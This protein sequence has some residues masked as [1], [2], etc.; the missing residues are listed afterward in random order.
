MNSLS[1]YGNFKAFWKAVPYTSLFLIY[2]L[3]FSYLSTN[4]SNIYY[5]RTQTHQLS[6]LFTF[7]LHG[8]LNS[9]GYTHSFII[10]YLKLPGYTVRYIIH[11]AWRFIV[12]R[13]KKHLTIDSAFKIYGRIWIA[14]FILHNVKMPSPV[15]HAVHD[16]PL[17][18]QIHTNEM[19]QHIP[20]HYYIR[21]STYRYISL[22]SKHIK[23]SH[24]SRKWAVTLVIY[25]SRRTLRIHI[26]GDHTWFSAFNNFKTYDDV[27]LPT[28]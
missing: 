27:C 26:R 2:S 16:T 25:G 22:Q 8:Y 7:V 20:R 1:L 14:P 15:A 3:R 9:R 24:K 21:T 6:L 10:T 4:I 23:H 17:I 13:I 5:I 12:Y 28:V 11:I 18:V 19:T